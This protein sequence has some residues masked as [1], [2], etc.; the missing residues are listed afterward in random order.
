MRVHYLQDD[1]SSNTKLP[2]SLNCLLA[3]TFVWESRPLPLMPGLVFGDLWALLCISG[4]CV[5]IPRGSRHVK[6]YHQKG[7]NVAEM[8]YQQNSK[9]TESSPHVELG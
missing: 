3:F 4:V 9:K 8:S 7:L 1:S 5:G 6:D 2:S